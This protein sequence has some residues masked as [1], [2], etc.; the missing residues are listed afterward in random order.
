MAFDEVVA[1]LDVHLDRSLAGVIVGEPELLERTAFTQPALFAIEVALSSVVPLRG[2]P[3][4]S[5]GSFG[6]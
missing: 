4:L 3:G 5:G 6:G 2:D 1:A